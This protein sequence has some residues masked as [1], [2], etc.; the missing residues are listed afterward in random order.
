MQRQ[1]AHIRLNLD[2][3][4]PIALS[5]F[6]GQF[7][8]LGSQFEKYLSQEHPDLK[9]KTEFYVQEVRKGSIEADLAWFAASP[10]IGAAGASAKWAI[11]KIDQAQILGK[12]IEGFKERL[13]PYF[14]KG[15]RAPNATKGELNDFNKTVRAITRDRKGAVRLEAAVF[16]D[17]DR[18]I[19]AQFKFT[20]EEAQI[21][22]A[23]ISDHIQELDARSDI[24]RERVLLRFVR[25]SAEAGKPGKKG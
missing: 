14:R 16:K 18:N 25:P 6:V 4:E 2:T 10:A 19:E 3:D 7:V 12:F 22:E 17:G 15:G 21:A 1:E 11:D 23:E 24:N 13:S 8:G 20:S 9:S 5:D